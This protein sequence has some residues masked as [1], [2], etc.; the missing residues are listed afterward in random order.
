M[1][2]LRRVRT[3]RTR[4]ND[5]MPS[6][7]KVVQRRARWESSGDA[8]ERTQSSVVVEGEHGS[9]LVHEWR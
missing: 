7:M 9:R 2:A 8:M 5:M 4:W 6:L 1:D 3:T